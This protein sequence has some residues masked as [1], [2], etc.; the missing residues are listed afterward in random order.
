MFRAIPLLFMSANMAYAETPTVVSSAGDRYSISE[1]ENG[2]ILTSLY[3]KSRFVE[4]GANSYVV[5][6]LDVIYFGKDCDAFH[7]VFGKGTFGWANGGFLATFESGAEIGFPRQDL[8]WEHLT[9]CR[10]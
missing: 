4:A 2:G 7:K 6:G 8:P 9:K 5:D 3:P 1:N 10:L